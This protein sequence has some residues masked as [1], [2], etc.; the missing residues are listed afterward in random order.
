MINPGPT[1]PLCKKCK[2]EAVYIPEY[3]LEFR[4]TRPDTIL[5][6]HTWV[7]KKCGY[8]NC[9]KTHND[10]TVSITDAESIQKYNIDIDK[11]WNIPL[12][13]TD[14]ILAQKAKRLQRKVEE[15][16]ED[17]KFNKLVSDYYIT[18][19]R[20]NK[21]QKDLPG[22][23]KWRAVPKP[24]DYRQ[25]RYALIGDKIYDIITYRECAKA[26]QLIKSFG[27]IEKVC[28]HENYFTCNQYKN[29]RYYYKDGEGYYVRP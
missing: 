29:T 18:F 27:G 28:L 17:E 12:I 10:V 23:F 15:K 4:D 11:W 16:E 13:T 20:L 2:Y 7:C 14:E 25:A 6:R 26:N 8:R 5:V 9:R 1:T 22:L 24:T 21:F 3:P 19:E